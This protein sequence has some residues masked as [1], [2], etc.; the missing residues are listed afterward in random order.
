MARRCSR[1][2]GSWCGSLRR[3]SLSPGLSLALLVAGS[4]WSGSGRAA[5]PLTS[6][7]VVSGLEQPLFVTAAPGDASRLF[8]V[9]Q[10]GRIR[11]V[12]LTADPPELAATAFLDITDRVVDSANERGL[13]GLAFH[14]DF[15]NNGWFYV[16]YTGVGG[17]TVVS[18]FSVPAQTPQLADATSEQT[19]LTLAQPQ[20]NHNGGWLGF[21]PLDGML[22]I[23][24]G[25]GGGGGDDDAGHTAGI[26]NSQDTTSNLLGKL[27]R[28]DV[29][30]TSA[31]GGS[32]GIPPD[33]PFVGATGDDE[34]WAYG[35]RNPWRN[36]FDRETG[37]L[38]IADV[39]QSSWEEVD[40]QLAS[41]AGGEN[42]G[43]RCREGAHPFDTSASCTATSSSDP[44]YEYS[45]GGSPFRCAVTGG[46]VYRGC[47]I[48]DLQG[49]YFLADFCSSQIWSLKMD[50][51]VAT[52]VT[53]RTAELAPGGGVS[54]GSISS[55][56]L[57]ALGELYIVDRGGEVFRVV[58]DGV[59]SQCAQ[60][61]PTFPPWATALT[62]L[63]IVLV[64]ALFDIPETLW[65]DLSAGRQVIDA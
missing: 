35:L 13:L 10:P 44:V 19:L 33:N 57:D 16:D 42:W 48:P 63:G 21:G 12:D 27:L 32:Y 15:Q 56:G 46:E 36:A 38:Y 1:E 51:G 53:D 34:I 50:G 26:G 52:Q 17:A 54:I 5:T 55:F 49:S 31:P 62:A 65:D 20:S 41:S 24:T 2:A 29:D 23:A 58:P 3:R 30:A 8:V 40:F 6:E 60:A 61:V 59:E 28:I 18:R 4:L 45:R 22:Y 14:P 47:A 43:W 9:E 25:D 7:L 64:A 11:I 37:D 39:G